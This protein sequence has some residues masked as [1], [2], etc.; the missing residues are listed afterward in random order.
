MAALV[1]PNPVTMGGIIYAVLSTDGYNYS[2]VNNYAKH[3]GSEEQTYVPGTIGPDGKY[4]VATTLNTPG[5]WEM[6]SECA[7]VTSNKVSLTCRGILVVI[8]LEHWSKTL[9]PDSTEIEVYSNY[10]G[11]CAIYASLDGWATETYITNTVI[12]SGGYGAV[13][14]NFDSLAYG[15]WEFDARIGG[16]TALGYGGSDW[17]QV[18][19]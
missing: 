16:Y 13:S 18:A 1:S 19:R 6:W 4:E 17:V 10:Q 8:D 11:N 2:P 14:A 3:M 15:H 5:Y 9:G 12:N 7:G